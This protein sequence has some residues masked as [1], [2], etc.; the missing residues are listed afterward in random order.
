MSDYWRRKYE[1]EFSKFADACG[2][3]AFGLGRHALALL[4]KA[5]DVQPGD[6][7]GVCAFTCLA[8]VEAVKVCG[9]VPIYLDIDEHL[10][11]DPQE[12][13][14]QD[15][16]SL[17][18]VILQHTFGN[19]GRFDE[20]LAA[21]KKIGA[22][23]IEDCAHSLHSTWNGKK[24]GTFGVGAVNQGG[25]LTINSSKLLEKVDRQI[26]LFSLPTSTKSEFIPAWLRLIYHPF[27]Q[28][29]LDCFLGYNYSRLRGLLKSRGTSFLKSDWPPL[30]GFP[31]LSGEMKAKEG[32]KKLENWRKLQQTRL[33]NTAMIEDYFNNAGLTLCPRQPKANMTLMRY[34]LRVYKKWEKVHRAGIRGLDIAG[35][36]N[37]PIHPLTG[38]D[39]AKVNYQEGSCPLSEGTIERLVHLPTDSSLNRNKLEAMIKIIQK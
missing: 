23:I 31:R 5:L 35:W 24:L 4:L 9:A 19:P 1:E 15:A 6:K 16:G 32:L 34:P 21:C 22:K 17:K 11:I 7:V 12:I 14:I 10:C 20:L 36:Y 3:R 37:S 26:K 33:E 39:L 2:A 8:V 13:L 25:M 28:S 29:H 38:N 30:L 18:A 27:S